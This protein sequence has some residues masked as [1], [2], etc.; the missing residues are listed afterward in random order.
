M[1]LGEVAPGDHIKVD[2]KRE[3]SPFRKLVAKLVPSLDQRNK[4]LNAVQAGNFFLIGSWKKLPDLS[5]PI[6]CIMFQNRGLGVPL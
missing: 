6:M 5:L 1:V 3:V 2:S 4:D